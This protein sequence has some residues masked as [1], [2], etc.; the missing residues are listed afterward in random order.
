MLSEI[1]ADDFTVSFT[2]FVRRLIHNGA[3]RNA[4]A[5]LSDVRFRGRYWVKSG[6]AFLHCTCL[7]LTQSGHVQRLTKRAALTCWN[8]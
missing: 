5:N 2:A 7:L 8:I 4:R 3:T 1:L 6:H